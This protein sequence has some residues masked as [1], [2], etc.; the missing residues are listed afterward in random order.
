[1]K[2]RV[3]VLGTVGKSLL[4][5]PKA[6]VGATIGTDLR[7][8]DGSV[9][10]LAQLKTLFA[11]D[12]PPAVANTVWKLIREIPPNVQEVEALATSGLVVRQSDGNWLTRSIAVEADGLLQ[13]TQANGD[14]GNPTL[15]AASIAAL[16]VWG[17]GANT[18]GK[19][20]PLVAGADKDVLRRAGTA[21]GF[22]ALDS[23]YITDFAE[24]AQDEVLGA[25]A[26]SARIDFAYDDALNAFTADLIS[27]SVANSYLANM[28]QA[29]IKGRASDAGTGVPTDLTGAQVAT[30]IGYTAAD[31]LAKL[32]TVDGTGS[33]LDA[34]FLDGISSGGFFQTAAV[35]ATVDGTIGAPA[36]TFASNTS[37]GV[38]RVGT[39]NMGLVAGGVAV[40]RAQFAGSTRTVTVGDGAGSSSLSFDAA[41][42][43]NRDLNFQSAGV[44]RWT[45]RI[46]ATA[47]A[48][49]NVGSDFDLI[50][51]DDAGTQTGVAVRIDR[52]SG[53]WQ[54]EVGTAAAPELTFSGDADTGM[55]RASANSLG[56]AAGGVKIGG[57]RLGGTTR[58]MEIGDGLSN[59]AAVLS[60]PAATDRDLFITTAGTNRWI[61]RV[62]STAEAGANAGSDFSL[63]RYSDAGSSLGTAV[64][65]A[66]STGQWLFEDGS[67]AAPELS[68]LLDADC[69]MY[70][71][72]T[73]V[74]G[75]AAGGTDVMRVVSTG[76]D[77]AVLD[78]I[79]KKTADTG[80]F[81]ISGGSA[82][83]AANGANIRIEGVDYLGAG[84]GG[85]ISLVTVT[86]KPVVI[87]GTSAQLHLQNG[88]A[89]LP[90]V[91]FSS[92]TDTGMFR[93]SANILG[94]AVNATEVVRI[95]S[96]G[97][98]I[99]SAVP[100][101]RLVETDA[102]ADEGVWRTDVNSRIHRVRAFNDA[103]TLNAS[104][105]AFTRGT[106]AT[107]SITD[108]TLGNATDNTT[109]NFPGTG[110]KTFGGQILAADGT[111]ALPTYA[112]TNDPDCGLY[113]IGANN[114]GIACNA[115]KVLDIAT[116]GLTVTG[117]LVLGTLGNGLA[118][119][120]GTN[121]AMGV[122]TL[123]AGTVVVSNTRVTANSRI[124]LTAQSL[125][126]V[127][128][129]SALGISAR[130]AGTS[131]TILAS[132]LTDTS[133]V[134]WEI[135]EPAP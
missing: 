26:D 81:V 28:A 130:T 125:G 133:V 10:T 69:G 65:V 23:T 41:A 71:V 5:D 96:T 4:I 107:P 119:K 124:R 103:L 91:A 126:T 15:G 106:G 99:S 29:T 93:V 66:R 113:R 38:Y 27:A 100:A 2:A 47:E 13:I 74:L 63:L 134:A 58:I 44:N 12:A 64:R 14:A 108:V 33:L 88:S 1:M 70:R 132:A 25:I 105:L 6:T 11:D 18:A 123:V 89:V 114:L 90:S 24:R 80:R 101:F 35:V 40:M 43:A 97:I 8:E 73:N 46:N 22:G 9:P 51:R 111:P 83:N 19:P 84:L 86:S 117:N 127:A 50:R 31:V 121:A 20:A 7:L 72:S 39:N 21:V 95:E 85:S 102:S 56:F 57:F 45:Q 77:L 42:G 36:W 112:L 49:S 122:A 16:S 34:D 128:V 52:A 78:G 87:A 79:L 131:F 76:F 17:R 59:V 3:P 30:I 67:A 135:V 32:L 94:F 55:Y 129:P 48:G 116:T 62:N 82:N 109:S 75:F 37:L 53:Q 54:F 115:G 120:E 98:A 104:A 61:L 68:F 110:T 118:I 92:D 60:G